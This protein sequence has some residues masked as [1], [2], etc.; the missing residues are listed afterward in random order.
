MAVFTLGVLLSS[1]LSGAQT[2]ANAQ[3]PVAASLP[4]LNVPGDTA[5]L[6]KLNTNLDLEQSKTGDEVQAETTH[7]VK[8]GKDVLLK[9]GSAL[10][11]HV[12]FVEPASSKQPENTVGI[13][14]DRVKPKNGAEQ[15]LH[16][17]VRALA[18]QS[19]A[20]ANSQIAGGRGMP[21][22]TDK[23]G[24]TGRDRAET[25]GVE[26]LNTSS[27]GVLNLP[28]LELGI[29]KG[30]AGGQQTT[31]LAWSKGDIKLKKGSQLVMLVVGQ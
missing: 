25:G 26:A 5:I 18:P 14:F 12:A 7:D 17:I 9:K 21:G 1:V 8:Q 20:P 31:I 11:G 23:A 24:V 2:P 28:G 6:A 30:A 27:V 15:S 4:T 22:E 10:I 16:L 13:V 19:E 29:R 3:T